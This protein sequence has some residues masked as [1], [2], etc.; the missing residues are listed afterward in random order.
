MNSKAKHTPGK[1]NKTIINVLNISNIYQP[2]RATLQAP[3]IAVK[4]SSP[5]E[6]QQMRRHLH[7]TSADQN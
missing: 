6:A 5:T 3:L 1:S 7:L 2:P 4:L